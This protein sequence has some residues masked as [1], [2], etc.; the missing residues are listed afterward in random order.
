MLINEKKIKMMK[1]DDRVVLETAKVAY[2]FEGKEPDID[3][4]ISE[5]N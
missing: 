4:Y 1:P 5:K 3:G 2:S